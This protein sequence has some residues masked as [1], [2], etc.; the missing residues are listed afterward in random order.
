MNKQNQTM[1]IQLRKVIKTYPDPDT[2]GSVPV[3]DVDELTID[4]GAHIAIEGPSGSGKTTLLHILSG[5]ILPDSGSV[6]IL[7][8]EIQ[9]LGEAHRD[10]FRGKHIGYIFQSF[11]LLEGFTALE[12]VMLGMMFGTG[13]TDR[14]R[15]ARLLDTV[16]LANRLGY[17]P[18]Q[19]STGQQQR[20]CIARALANNPEIILADEPTGNLDP[21]ASADV[22]NLLDEVTTGKTLVLVSHEHDVLMRYSSRISSLTFKTAE[23]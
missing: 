19:L 23:A 6:K 4:Q 15:A 5:L 21:A 10:R 22:L 20:V 13:K 2:G 3:L 16:G 18:S 17:R 8:T 14:S 11:N 12:N 9:Q 1:S 7:D